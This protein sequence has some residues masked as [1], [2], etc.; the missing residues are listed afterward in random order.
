M[1]KYNF[2]SF[3]ESS[4]C[5]QKEIFDHFYQKKLMHARVCIHHYKLLISS[6]VSEQNFAIHKSVIFTL[7]LAHYFHFESYRE[8]FILVTLANVTKMETNRVEQSVQ[9]Q[10]GLKDLD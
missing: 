9:T 2:L 6:A 5:L 7:Q 3:K 1:N 10:R 8:Y 4:L